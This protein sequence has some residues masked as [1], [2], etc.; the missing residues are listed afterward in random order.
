MADYEIEVSSLESKKS[1]LSQ[2][3][4]KAEQIGN[5]YNSTSIKE[6]KEGYNNVASK[7]TKNMER[8]TKGYTNSDTWLNGYITDL[9]ALEASLAS[10]S[11]D[12][13]TKPI[14]FKGT[15]E[16][17]F[18][19]VTMPAIK[20]GGDPNCNAKLVE[21]GPSLNVELKAGEGIDI[22][23]DIS[24]SGYTVTGYDYWIDSGNKMIWSEGTGQ[25][26]VSEIWQ[27]Q[28]SRFK[29][30]IAIVTVNGEDRYL[31]AVAPTFGKAGDA[32]DIQLE[33]GQK[34][35][36]IIGDLKSTGDSNYTRY[37]HGRGDGS[38]NVLEW[39]VQRSVYKEH[40]NPTTSKWGLEWDSSSRVTRIENEGSII[41]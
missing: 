24:Q 21:L 30:G 23:S 27:E 7:I 29:N 9:N 38:V 1:T 33:N 31:V 18:G 41:R 35:P 4:G 22:P 36:A 34:I 5:S 15:F 14:E 37:G 26:A 32:I 10:F 8:L 11:S 13:L 12:T 3:S 40:G 39:E 25:R 2:M 19:K 6:A 28:G 16:D 20:T 17:I